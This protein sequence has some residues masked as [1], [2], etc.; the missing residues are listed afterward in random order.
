VTERRLRIAFVYDALFPYVKGGAERRYH[1][2][3]RRLSARHDVHLVSWTWWDGAPDES[4][5][6]LTL[7]GVGKPPAMYG[8]DGKRTVR[9]AAAFSARVLPVLLR[10]KWDVIDCAATPYLPLWST[11]LASRVAGARLTVTWHEFWGKHW[12]S[13]LPRRPIVAEVARALE[14]ASRR[15]GDDIVAVSSF[16]ANAMGLPD[17]R[18]RVVPNGVTLSEIAAAPLPNDAADVVYVGRLIDEKR[19][20]LLIRAARMLHAQLPALRYSI[21]GS[22]PT[23][24]ELQALSAELGMG[25]RVTFHGQLEADEAY[26]RM[27]AARLLVLPS[28]REGYGMAVA[29]AQAA[30]T[31]PIVIRSPTSGAAD[32]IRDGKDGL[33][34]DPTP[35]ALADGMASL[36]ADEPRLRAMGVAARAAGIERDWERLADAMDAVYRGPA[37][38]T[39]VPSLEGAS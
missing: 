31:V 17:G 3:A 32:L 24:Q 28:I 18:V 39:P 13:Y 27:K 37:G 25:D 6:G 8:A 2:L 30:G 4:L 21:V 29:E 20:D 15:V 36:L 7:H 23:D 14:S 34:V 9:E 26:G 19:V 35:E 22:G 5:D 12:R 16:T 11:W 38:T 33:V 1:E 10:G